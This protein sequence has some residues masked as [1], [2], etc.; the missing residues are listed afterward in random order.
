M[1]VKH[2]FQDVGFCKFK[3][4]CKFRHS[5]GICR[6]PLC[7]NIGCQKRHPKP[8]RNLFMKNYCHYGGDCKYDHYVE[9][10]GCEN[11][12]FLIEKEA[13]KSKRSQID[14]LVAK[15]TLELSEAK[16]EIN[17]LKKEK[18]AF[19]KEVSSLK[20]VQQKK[21]LEFR[22]V[23]AVNDKLK[24]ENKKLKVAENDLRIGNKALEKLIE[25]AGK[26]DEENQTLQLA[27]E[28]AEDTLIVVQKEL[29]NS[30]ETKSL[31]KT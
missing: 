10:E 23:E 15:I 21:D 29:E 22:K 19:I 26:L 12:K 28:V 27:A 6:E 20:S 16:G 8:C 1:A 7:R 14:E 3:R 25:K 30:K 9:C 2:Y 18:V 24:K 4:R 11:L 17:D 13:Y 31:K 5:E